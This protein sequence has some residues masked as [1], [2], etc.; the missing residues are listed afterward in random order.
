MNP[1]RAIAVLFLTV[2]SVPAQERGGST[3][4]SV[5]KVEFD[6][7]DGSD[8]A[9][10]TPRR[11]VMMIEADDK[12]DFRVGQKVPYATGS[13]QPAVSSGGT[14][15]NVDSVQLRGSRREHRLPAQG[16]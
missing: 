13:L 10:R 14:P 15:V 2:L 16:G 8:A 5:Y 6:I 4:P 3:N 1:T 9:S 7:R 11:Y 12:G